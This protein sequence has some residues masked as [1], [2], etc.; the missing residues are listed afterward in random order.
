MSAGTHIISNQPQFRKF[1]NHNSALVNF[2]VNAISQ[3]PSSPAEQAGIRWIELRQDGDGQP[4][5]I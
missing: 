4:W 3:N 5:Y 1:A 2:T